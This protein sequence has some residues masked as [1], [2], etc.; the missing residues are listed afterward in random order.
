MKSHIIIIAVFLIILHAFAYSGTPDLD[1]NISL[2]FEDVPI[3]T[4]L[5]MVAQQYN[6]NLVQSGRIEGNIS[7][8]LDSVSLEDA[9][10]AILASNGFNYYT[11]G[12]I[13]VV[14]PLELSASGEMTVKTVDLHYIPPVA[15]ISAAEGLLSPKGSIKIIA[16]PDYKVART[17]KPVPSKIAIID[18]PETARL[19]AEFIRKIDKRE[20]QIA[21]EVRLVETN[22]DDDSEVG[23]NW[24]SSIIVRG[25]G[26][27]AGNSDGT[28]SSSD[29]S[30]AV[31]QID[32]PDG[33]WDWGKLSINELSLVLDFLEKSGNSKLIS[34][35]KITTLNNHPAE[36]K[37][38]TVVPI[39]TINRFS[40]GG[41]IQ[42]I[43]TFQDEEVGITLN[44]T[45][46]IAEDNQIILDVNSTVSEIIGY[47]GTA[48]NQK[49]ITAER[50]I[51]TRITVINEETAVLGGLFKEDKIE[52]E[53][54][55]FFLGSIPIIGGLFRHKSSEV[56]TTDLTI[57][58]TPRILSD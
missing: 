12:N 49:P 33:K 13:I 35:P 46:H 56:S 11:A 53:E 8:K 40:E 38:A 48:D 42:D 45:P 27:D 37:V 25:H 22:I 30:E 29:N 20:P 36:I 39:Q 7:I 26:I 14:K 41:S 19:T 43:V 4:V 55:V 18:V 34:D 1:A 57:M 3:S 15:A 5:N 51:H 6:L 21:I 9:L 23:F 17:G 2:Q 44:V 52:N 32:L 58:I 31:G 16:D 28:V 47:S 24:P 10:H 50:S 54:R